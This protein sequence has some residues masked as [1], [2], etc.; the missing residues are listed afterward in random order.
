MPEDMC[1]KMMGH[2][3]RGVGEAYYDR[4]EEEVFADVVAEAYVRYRA[5]VNG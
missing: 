5:G 4:P 2:A 3:G 1:E